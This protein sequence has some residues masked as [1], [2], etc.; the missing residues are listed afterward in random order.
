[1]EW[2]GGGREIFYIY[3]TRMIC[4]VWLYFTSCS[5]GLFR[6][7]T[8]YVYMMI[9]SCLCII[10]SGFRAHGLVGGG[11][12]GFKWGEDVSVCVLN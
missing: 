4:V 5:V 10:I 3:T 8:T 9:V 7:S 12:G 1:M 11:G 2:N 6:T